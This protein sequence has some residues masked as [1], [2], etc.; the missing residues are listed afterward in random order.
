MSEPAD[1][2][3]DLF[4]AASEPPPRRTPRS[5]VAAL[6]VAVL[7]SAA[8]TVVVVASQPT[9][10]P[11]ATAPTA[12]PVIDAAPAPTPGLT[13]LPEVGHPLPGYR[14]APVG[15]AVVGLEETGATVIVYD[16]RAW[17]RTVLPDWVVC[18]QS[19]TYSSDDTPTGDVHL[20]AVPV[21]DP[22]P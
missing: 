16:A 5:A 6:T 14:G 1:D 7:A 9:P 15:M 12:S 4:G 18:N 21:G 11:A 22:C 2:L 13:S 19:E 17:G 20:S 3:A 10:Q 8:A